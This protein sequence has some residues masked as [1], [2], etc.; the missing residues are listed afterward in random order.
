MNAPTFHSSTQKPETATRQ[1][2]FVLASLGLRPRM[3]VT[4]QNSADQWGPSDHCRIRI[5]LVLDDG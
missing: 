5:D 2:D 1:L 3:T 4:A